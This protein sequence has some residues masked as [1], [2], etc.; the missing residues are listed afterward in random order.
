MYSVVLAAALTTGSATPDWIF[1]HGCFGCHGCYG[2]SGGCH[3]CNGCG[4]C[5]GCYGCYGCG[6]CWGCYGC[7]G[8]SGCSGCSGYG[9]GSG[10]GGTYAYT[11]YNFYSCGGC[12]GSW[13]C[14]GGGATYFAPTTQLMPPA[15]AQV[16]TPSA[17]AKVTVLMPEDARL[18]VDDV[19]YPTIQDK[20]TFDT[21]ALSSERT[22]Y[23]TLKAE[24]IRDGKVY[25]D[26]RRVDLIAGRETRVEF[27][28]LRSVH[29]VQR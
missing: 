8:C 12:S 4:G 22:Y 3:G 17:T 5:W 28:D 7:Y 20:I 23:Y 27:K 1:G 24:A 26:I 9:G 18:Y 13:G 29:T 15:R 6:G 2:C 19:P 14:Y 11:P 16:I 25:R 10:W 21:P